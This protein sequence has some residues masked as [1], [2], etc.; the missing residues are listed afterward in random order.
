MKPDKNPLRDLVARLASRPADENAGS[1]LC[2]QMW[3]FVFGIVFRRLRGNAQAA[4]DVTQDVFLNLFRAKPFSKLQEPDLFRS[5]LARM[6][7]NASSSY[8][9]FVLGK[10]EIERTPEF[11]EAV[12]TQLAEN[13]SQ[14]RTND[15]TRLIQSIMPELEP[16]ERELLR[17]VLEGLTT[18]EIADAMGMRYS[19]A[20]VRLHRL[21]N[22]LRKC[23]DSK[24]L[25]SGVKFGRV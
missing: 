25:F 2:R 18:S 8:L 11:R 3:P 13:D 23:L 5:Y 15:L 10:N 21:R 22:R 7:H 9:R 17:L 14:L 16:K 6:A 20:G 24:E 4:E 12:V 19:N 1:E